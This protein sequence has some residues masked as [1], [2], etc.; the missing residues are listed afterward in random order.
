MIGKSFGCFTIVKADDFR[1]QRWIGKCECGIERSLPEHRLAKPNA[2]I[3]KCM[4]GSAGA[5][6][7]RHGMSYEPIYA[8]WNS[9]KVRCGNPNFAAYDR[10]G[11]RGI[12]V[13][14]RWHVFENFLEDMGPTYQPGLTL[15]RKDNDGPY[16]KEN[17][18]W[19]T[20]ET[21]N[22]NH[23]S[24]VW[25]DTCRGR[26]LMQDA[27]RIAGITWR[28][29]ANRVKSGWTGERLFAANTSHNKRKAA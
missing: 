29:M 3:C 18:E 28:G 19:A 14:E 27:A 22:R 9:M 21:Q 10:Y 4:K 5:Q 7:S 26:M 23:S 25:I 11:G 1:P 8:V 20:V 2:L 15:E 6:R 12:A 17:C 13:C 24:N 16:C